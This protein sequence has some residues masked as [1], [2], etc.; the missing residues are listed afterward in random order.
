MVFE[1]VDEM[2]N[3]KGGRFTLDNTEAD[4]PMKAGC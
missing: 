2:A 4:R 1:E 3:Q